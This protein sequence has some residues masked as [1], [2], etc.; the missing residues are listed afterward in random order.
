MVA[1]G[2]EHRAGRGEEAV[3]AGCRG[4]FA[5]AGAEDETPLHV[6]GDQAVVLERDGEAVDGGPRQMGCGHQ[7][8][9]RLRTGFQSAENGSRLVEHSDA[10]AVVS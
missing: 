4:Q 3:F 7:L 10:R 9:E 1:Q 8:R 5:E 2:D 6:A